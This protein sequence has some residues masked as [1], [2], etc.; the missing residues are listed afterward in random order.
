V[1]ADPKTPDEIRT[2]VCMMTDEELLE[3]F[4]FWR[5]GLLVFLAEN[6]YRAKG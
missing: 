2:L 1:T 5:L 4:V 6:G 3:L